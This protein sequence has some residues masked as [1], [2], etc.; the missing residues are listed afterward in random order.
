M[1]LGRRRKSHPRT[2]TKLTRVTHPSLHFLSMSGLSLPPVVS[3]HVAPILG[4]CLTAVLFWSPMLSLRKAK[5]AGTLGPVLFIVLFLLL[6]Y[7]VGF[8]FVP[9][10][11]LSDALASLMSDTE[12]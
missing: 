10:W 7:C 4:I 8:L 5:A 1:C 12:V 11:D 6:V 3:E 2:Y 9:Y